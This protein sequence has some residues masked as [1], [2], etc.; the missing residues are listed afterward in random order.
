MCFDRVVVGETNEDIDLRKCTV[1]VIRILRV[2]KLIL[3]EL[4]FCQYNETF[5]S[6]K[7][8]V[9]VVH[10]F[11]HLLGL[12]RSISDIYE[13]LVYKLSSRLGDEEPDGRKMKVQIESFFLNILQLPRIKSHKPFMDCFRLW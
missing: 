8:E 4:S 2:N 9:V 11:Y 7:L 12:Q 1:R 6:K 13:G 10:P 5:D 3:Y